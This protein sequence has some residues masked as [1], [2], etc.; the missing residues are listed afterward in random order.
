M[1]EGLFKIT[2]A[3]SALYQFSSFTTLRLCVL[4]ALEL[5]LSFIQGRHYVDA[6]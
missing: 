4:E 2:K 1:G 6:I 5:E 3:L